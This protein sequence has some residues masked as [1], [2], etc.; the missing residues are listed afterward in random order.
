MTVTFEVGSVSKGNEQLQLQ[1]H[2]LHLSQFAERSINN[3]RSDMK[4]LH[5]GD[6][7]SRV[8]VVLE[9]QSL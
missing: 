3:C 8:F 7:N 1:L 2:R 9:S 5:C 6:Q 4:F